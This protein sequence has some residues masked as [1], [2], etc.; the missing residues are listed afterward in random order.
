MKK[1]LT[2]LL[3]W[4]WTATVPITVLG[5]YVTYD[6]LNRFWTFSV[7]YDPKPA[8]L[9][10]SHYA[11]YAMEARIQD[12]RVGLSRYHRQKS[13]FRTVNLFV[14]QANLAILESHLPQ[15]G[16]EYVKGLI[17]IDGRL[18]K[19]KIRY[20][21]DYDYHWA[22]DKKSIRVKTDQD[23][24]F[25]GMRTF[26]LQAPKFALQLNNYLALQL[27]E[28]LGLLAPRS[29]LVNVNINRESRGVHIL[30]E[31]LKEE[32][33]RRSRLMPG[34]VYRGEIVGKDAF[35]DSGIRWLLDSSA[36][37]DKVAVNNHFDV[38]SMEPLDQFL[39]LVR[40]QDNPASQALLTRLLDMDAW[41]RFSVF[42][43]L[44]QTRHYGKTHNWRLY[45]DPWRR[46][47]V[48]IVW[49]PVGWAKGFWPG[50]GE[51]AVDEVIVTRLHEALF[52]NGDFVRARST[53]LQSYFNSKKDVDFL[54]TVSTTI[55]AMDKAIVHDRLLRPADP[56]QV[57]RELHSLEQTIRK[58]FAD[59]KTIAAGNPEDVRWRRD[60]DA[61][62]LSISGRRPVHRIRLEP[63]TGGGFSQSPRV[64][65]RY[66]GALGSHVVDVTGGV[67]VASEHLTLDVG[68]LPD[69]DVARIGSTAFPNEVIGFPALYRV[70]VEGLSTVGPVRFSVDLGGGWQTLPE[71]HVLDSS[72]RKSDAIEE[73]LTAGSSVGWQMF[74]S[75]GRGFNREQS[76]PGLE[77]RRCGDSRWCITREL[78]GDVENIRIDL[79]PVLGM[80]ISA[81]KL[82][83]DG[84][85][86][87]IKPSRIA[88]NMM[89]KDKVSLWP[90]EELD[91]YFYF[92]TTSYT[93]GSNANLH[94][95]KVSFKLETDSPWR[96]RL[97]EDRVGRVNRLFAAVVPHP[98]TRPLIWSGD[99]VISGVQYI[100]RPL[101]IEPGTRLLMEAGATLILS[102]RLQAEGTAQ[103][104]IRI[105]A[106]F[107]SQKPWGAIVLTGD[108]ASGSRLS[109]CEISGGSG[110]KGDLFEY[111]AMLSVHDVRDVRIT[112][113]LFRDS[114]LTDD[115][116][117][118]VYSDIRLER[119]TFMNAPGDA[120]DLDISSAVIVDS[121]FQDN[122]NDGVDL[123]TS[124]VQIVRSI[125]RRNGDKGISVGE[126][127][128]MIMI[129]S[130]L[131]NNL[132]GIQAKDGSVAALVNVTLENN[133]KAMDAY[134]K[135]WRY[136]E[137][138]MIVAAKC[139]ITE[140]PSGV[141]AGKRS[142]IVLFDSYWDRPMATRKVVMFSVDSKNMV[143]ASNHKLWPDGYKDLNDSETFLASLR[144]KV[145]ADTD[146]SKRGA[147]AAQR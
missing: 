93:S 65:V 68:L 23:R 27:A 9:R 1:F 55:A 51:S 12:A 130:T 143:S 105:L 81:I 64:T 127:S 70:S 37:W 82:T 125:F 47:V 5:A 95:V 139:R 62:L 7:R 6:A 43:T 120:V 76:T 2:I 129:D 49:D 136:G 80:Q 52:K 104:P 21:G 48:P 97:A 19:A 138:G 100:D 96:W 115:M 74:W 90:T 32:T 56:D 84:V 89:A 87:D 114:Q 106:R 140:N 110:L 26:N 30:I 78:P 20:R 16:F 31:Q 98:E 50:K 99:V 75:T 35:A 107:P 29:E 36:V 4:S 71:A 135:N 45:Y 72:L 24:L 134:K 53:F 137:G 111:T 38:N 145:I 109:H 67:A 147:Y 14:P 85:E 112:D 39:E 11:K 22:W 17:M 66:E 41:A 3:F 121:I 123:M 73:R 117:H 101:V 113:C 15:S 54:Q 126:A 34:D 44:A 28:Q 60:G 40:D 132:I 33:L 91:P 128:Q 42:E 131:T 86:H 25:D 103:N 92:G 79:P 144:P 124:D 69:L 142:R 13:P 10:L 133:E 141:T 77:L 118:G 116:L 102:E 83:V 88:T 94:Q 59:T 146:P 108:R 119:T 122:G 61:L 63:Y 46:K 58:I 18:V 57:S 8:E